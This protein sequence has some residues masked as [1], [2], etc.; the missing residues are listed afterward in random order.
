MTT[1]FTRFPT[2]NKAVL[3]VPY[4]PSQRPPLMKQFIDFPESDFQIYM[5]WK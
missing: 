2:E 1:Q 4:F 3:M 5:K